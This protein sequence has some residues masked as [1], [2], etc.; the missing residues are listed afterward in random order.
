MSS[1]TVRMQLLMHIKLILIPSKNT[2]NDLIQNLSRVNDLICL[3]YSNS[4]AAAYSS[5]SSVSLYHCSRPHQ[6]I[7]SYSFSTMLTSLFSSFSFHAAILLFKSSELFFPNII[8]VGFGTAIHFPSSLS[9][10]PSIL[11]LA[12]ILHSL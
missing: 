6:T 7:S 5:P 8:L 1:C 9:S 3:K 12:I 4:G 10:I 2:T 11:C